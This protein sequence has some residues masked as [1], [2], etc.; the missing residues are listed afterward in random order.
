MTWL[1]AEF[2]VALSVFVNISVTAMICF[3]I[4]QTRKRLEKVLDPSYLVKYTGA[5][6]ILI[7]SALP[8]SVFG[9]VSAAF[10]TNGHLAMLPAANAI[11]GAWYCL[12]VCQF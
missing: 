11:V 1:G 2:W 12:S 5:V 9:I 10:Y 3:R 6:S 8:F 4:I 7:E